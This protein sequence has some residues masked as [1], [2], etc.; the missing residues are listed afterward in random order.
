MRRMPRA[1]TRRS[2]VLGLPI[3]RRRTDWAKIGRAS[4]VG[5]SAIS[6][7]AD[8]A[9]GIRSARDGRGPESEH[10]DDRGGTRAGS[11]R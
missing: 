3:G 4:M 11:R 2:T 9:D 1:F 7:V 10:R 5:L 8:L 6:A